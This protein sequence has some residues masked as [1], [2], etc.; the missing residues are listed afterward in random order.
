VTPLEEIQAD[1][2][3]GPATA[4][5]LYRVVA[6]VAVGHGFRPPAPESAWTADAVAQVAHDFAADT[7]TP[8]RLAYLVVHAEDDAAFERI[9]NEMVLNFLRDRGRRTEIGRLMIRIREV[10]GRNA[11]FTS[12]P[13]DRWKLTAAP[14]AASTVPFA[15]LQSA[16]SA[17]PD[18][19]VPRWSAQS[20]RQAPAADAPSIERL[21]RRVLG[22]AEGSV[23]LD[24][25]AKAV[26][27]RLGLAA[28]PIAQ[29]VDN[30]DVFAEVAAPQRADAVVDAMRAEE[31][32][33]I[34]SERER[35]LLAT[36]GTPVRELRA[37]IGV[38][39]SQAAELQVRLRALLKLELADDEDY[40]SGFF[41]L[42]DRAKSWAAH[43][44]TGPGPTF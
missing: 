26:A 32:F 10:L 20:K 4:K 27:P 29:P 37:V 31:I 22:A 6:A 35:L 7:R 44:T 15:T 42:V 23:A 1:G 39:P 40:E 2:K 36:V 13:G 28:T 8:K 33:G 19:Q 12:V 18:V 24:E 21:C 11:D 43:R 3:A 41:H 34:L 14:D 5:L 17:E 38:G 16:A 30:R 9:L 25:L